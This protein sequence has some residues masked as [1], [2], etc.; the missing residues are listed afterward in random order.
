LKN[1]EKL[2]V[3][4]VSANKQ[5]SISKFLPHVLIVSGGIGLAA[6]FVIMLEK[7]TLL[8][9]P[10]YLP[11][12]SLNP[13][14]SCGPIMSSPQAGVFGFPNPII[15]LVTF[16]LVVCVGVGML[17]GAKYKRWY[18]LLFN[19]G[20]LLG[21]VFVL[22]LIFQSLY[23]IGALCLYCIVVW[24]VT[25]AAFWYTTLYNLQ[26]KNIQLPKSVQ[27]TADFKIR[28]HVNFLLLMYLL[29]LLLIIGRFWTNLI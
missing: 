6:S 1:L 4:T 2:T 19:L 15:G 28:H 5:L 10:T 25:I 12:C 21:F 9:N 14:L 7:L 13:I 29:I 17:A 22:W 23:V 24:V 11:S 18:W 27:G 16:P 20:T 8:Q 26:A 3:K